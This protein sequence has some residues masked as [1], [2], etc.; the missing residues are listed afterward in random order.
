MKDRRVVWGIGAAVG[1]AAIVLVIVL[2]TGNGSDDES[3]TSTP[4]STSQAPASTTEPPPETTAAPPETT[5]PPPETTAAPPPD[6]TAAPP[7]DTTTPPDGPEGAIPENTSGWQL[8]INP[9]SVDIT[10]GPVVVYWYRNPTSGNYIAVYTGEGVA[11]G[12]GLGFCPGNSIAIDDFMNISNAPTERGACD[13]FPTDVGSVQVCDHGVWIYETLIP[14]DAEGILFGSLEW[15][16]GDEIHGM[17]S[18][19]ETVADLPEFESGL[20]SYSIAPFMTVDGATVIACEDA[21]T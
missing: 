21:L 12:G 16:S 14:G 20:A 3:A 4:P 9:G 7:P 19:A 11:G 1:V 5:A 6:T 8:Q 13:D 17:S 10:T 2:A 18:Q 15:R